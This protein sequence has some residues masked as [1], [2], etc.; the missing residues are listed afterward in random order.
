MIDQKRI[1]SK[2]IILFF[3]ILFGIGLISI[4]DFGVSSDEHNTR[5]KG[6]I[7]L[8]YLGEKFIPEINQD[9]KDDKD[10]ATFEEAGRIKYYGPLFDAPVAL[11][12]VLLGI[13]DKKD[14]FL[15]KHYFCF[16]LFFISLIFFFK[17]ANNRFE[18]KILALLGV[19]IIFLSPRI[20]ANSFY[21]GKDLVFMSFIIFSMYFGLSF[22]KKPNFKN[23]LKFSLFAALAIDIRVLGVII[24]ALIFGII[25]LKIIVTKKHMKEYFLNSF[26]ILPFLSIFITLF[27]PFLWEAPVNNFID[28]FK[29]MSNYEIEILNFF[30]GKIISAGA[31]PWNYIPIWILIT[32]PIFYIIFF[33]IGLVNFLINLSFF[34]K[35]KNTNNFY[36]DLLFLM[37]IFGSIFSVIFLGSTLLNGWRHFYFIYPSFVMITLCGF[38]YIYKIIQKKSYK[39]FFIAITFISFFNIGFWMFNNHPHQYV[40]FNNFVNKDVEKKYEMDYWGLSYKENF[41]YLLSIDNRNKI[42][43]WNASANNIFYHLFAIKEEDRKR[44]QSVEFKE[45]ADYIITNFYI[46]KNTYDQNFLNSYSIVKEILVDGKSINTLYKKK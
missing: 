44:I 43:V 33:L 17:I 7:T 45:E 34:N 32:T 46:D 18:N 19:L 6:F 2:Y 36:Q 1:S 10:I 4:K 25:F 11:F 20:F 23:C 31:V 9:Y 21:N 42:K 39:N 38:N 35:I 16:F 26:L 8:N 29:V 28:A 14:Q 3:V 24:P 41:E 15:F 37:L 22:F 40:F 13:K 5:L 27:W 12:E 30:R